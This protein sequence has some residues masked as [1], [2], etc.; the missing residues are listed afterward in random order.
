MPASKQHAGLTTWTGLR[1][2]F[3]AKALMKLVFAFSRI[4]KCLA[5]K[6]DDSV[7]FALYLQE[8]LGCSCLGKGIFLE[9]K[10]SR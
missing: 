4:A 5:C 1:A 6:L 8:S 3:H 7:M 10:E 9:T 2:K